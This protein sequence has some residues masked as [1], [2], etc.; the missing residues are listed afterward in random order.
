MTSM[1]PLSRRRLLAW[2]AA[3]L[4]AGPVPPAHRARE[5]QFAW[6]PTALHDRFYAD[7]GA[8]LFDD[9][10]AAERAP[11]RALRIYRERIR[12]REPFLVLAMGNAYLHEADA[13]VTADVPRADLD[14]CARSLPRRTARRYL[15]LCRGALD[16]FASVPDDPEAARRAAELRG[17][18]ERHGT[19]A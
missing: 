19:G 15:R 3:G 13:M 7:V 9:L 4:A 5:F 11:E 10:L 8:K 18:L 17:A 16:C 6:W 2:T 12:P 1:E 14:A